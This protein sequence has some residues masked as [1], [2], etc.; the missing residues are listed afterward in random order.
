MELSN[1]D[2]STLDGITKY[3]SLDDLYALILAGNRTFNSNLRRSALELRWEPSAAYLVPLAQILEFAATFTAHKCLEICH[4]DMSLLDSIVEWDLFSPNLTSLTLDLPLDASAPNFAQIFP[5]LASLKVHYLDLAFERSWFPN[6]LTSLICTETRSPYKHMDDLLYKLP[7]HLTRLSITTRMHPERCDVPDL[8]LLPL[9]EVLLNDFRMSNEAP[10]SWSFLPPTITHLEACVGTTTGKY[11]H[12]YLPHPR[13]WAAIFPK[14]VHLAVRFESLCAYDSS[15]YFEYD[16]PPSFTSLNVLQL[17]PIPSWTPAVTFT[18]HLA[19]THGPSLRRLSGLC[20]S[21]QLYMKY[22]YNCDTL[23]LMHFPHCWYTPEE[24]EECGPTRRVEIHQLMIDFLSSRRCSNVTTIYLDFMPSPS[25]LR[26]LPPTITT[27]E[28]EVDVDKHFNEIALSSERA[29][30]LSEPYMRTCWPPHLLKLDFKFDH[31]GVDVR[32]H[33]PLLNF[34]SL[35]STLRELSVKFGSRKPNFEDQK[36]FN[37]SDG[38]GDGSSGGSGFSRPDVNFNANSVLHLHHFFS[39]YLSHLICLTYL[40]ISAWNLSKDRFYITSPA[41]LPPSLTDMQ[42][43]DTPFVDHFVILDGFDEK[44]GTHRFSNMRQLTWS[45]LDLAIKAPHHPEGISDIELLQRLPRNLTYLNFDTQYM[46]NSST[47]WT[48]EHFKALPRT[49]TNLDFFDF[50][51]IPFANDDD[52][53]LQYLPPALNRLEFLGLLPYKADFK[54]P[55]LKFFP[56][57]LQSYSLPMM[58]NG[59][60]HII[61]TAKERREAY[62]AKRSAARMARGAPP[63][64]IG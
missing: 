58:N 41:Q 6:S 32:A 30:E 39:G 12:T 23:N 9:K 15:G 29:T 55:N 8:S 54:P 26:S 52:S 48:P 36:Y 34:E 46:V 56:S 20:P 33:K 28:L 14:L 3:L 24:E 51:K 40:K 43:S 18:L 59:H 60:L 44:S 11:N 21:A 50:F 7:P 61:Q 64:P 17:P 49:L 42:Q 37:D 53:C 10:L 16:F 25:Q 19:K 2:P 13:S 45:T 31:Y 1:L 62:E 57:S 63:S 47:G 4:Y 35:P 27:I 38:S 5:H 22:F